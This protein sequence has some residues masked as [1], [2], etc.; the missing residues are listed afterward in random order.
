MKIHKLSTILFIICEIRGFRQLEF[1]QVAVEHV[2]AVET[3]L[4]MH[5][6]TIARTIAVTVSQS[7]DAVRSRQSR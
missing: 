6:V 2:E 5:D 3:H 7:L 4:G 1:V